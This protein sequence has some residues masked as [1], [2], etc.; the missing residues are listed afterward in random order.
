MALQEADGD[1]VGD[2]Q[3][4]ARR[5]DVSDAEAAHAADPP[6]SRENLLDAVAG[7]ARLE[8]TTRLE[9]DDLATDAGRGEPS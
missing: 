1:G 3:D 8:F 6:V 5:A 9:H 4:A 2:V 7:L